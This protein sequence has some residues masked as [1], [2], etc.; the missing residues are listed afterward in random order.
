LRK[1]AENQ[2][3][4]LFAYHVISRLESYHVKEWNRILDLVLNATRDAVKTVSSLNEI[5]D[6]KIVETIRNDSAYDR[7]MDSVA[8]MHSVADLIRVSADAASCKSVLERLDE[9]KSHSLIDK[10]LETRKTRV[11]FE[12]WSEFACREVLTDGKFCCISLVPMNDDTPGASSNER[13]YVVAG[14]RVYYT[15]CAKILIALSK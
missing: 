1:L 9:I 4:A 3:K 12:Q 5:E 13:P 14:D 2:R 10:I 8:S 7:F 6:E 15:G 11:T